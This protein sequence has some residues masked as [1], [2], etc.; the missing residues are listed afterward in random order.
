MAITRGVQW[1]LFQA[2]GATRATFTN[3]IPA[4]RGPER[5]ERDQAGTHAVNNKLLRS[6]PTLQ[7]GRGAVELV[8][9]PENKLAGAWVPAWSRLLA[10][11]A[12]GAGMTRK[13]SDLSAAKQVYM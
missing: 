11:L 8:V 10:P 12:S 2:G 5:P 4:P 1:T 3:V 13:D 6:V 7:A 9:R